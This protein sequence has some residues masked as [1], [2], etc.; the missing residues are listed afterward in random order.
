MEK[1]VDGRSYQAQAPLAWH[2]HVRGIHAVTLV[3][4]HRRLG[5]RPIVMDVQSRK[6]LVVR[7]KFPIGGAFDRFIGAE[8]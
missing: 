4:E 5:K 7:C 6:Y 3:L 2:S 8:A 1:E